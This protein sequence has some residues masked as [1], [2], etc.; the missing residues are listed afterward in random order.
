MDDQRDNVAYEGPV[1][2]SD[3]NPDQA[4]HRPRTAVSGNEP[5]SCSPDSA[6]TP[7]EHK[8]AATTPGT[9]A[10]SRKEPV[11][12]P[13]V[14]SGSS[15]S[16]GTG[17]PEREQPPLRW[18]EVLAVGLL[19]VVC[20]LT[21]Y[22]GQGFAGHA[23]LFMA[24]PA[25]LALGSFRACFGVRVWLVGL[26]VVLLAA[27]MVWCGSVLLVALGFG[28]LVAFA[29]TLSGLPP[30][31]LEVAVFASQTI[32][33][34]YEGL[35]CYWRSISR[36][37]PSTTRVAWLNIVLPLVTFLLFGLLFILANPDLLTWFGESVGRF[38]DSLR[39]WIISYSPRLSEVLFCLAVLWV[40]I[41][42]LRPVMRRTLFGETVPDEQAATGDAPVP[43]QAFLYPAFRNTLVTVIV[44]FASYLVF[45]FKTLWFRVFPEG[46]YYSGYAHEGAAWLTLALA[47]A[48]VILSL[49]F[50]GRVLQDP[51]LPGLRRLAW[52]WSVENMVLAGAVYNRLYIYIGFNGMSRMRMVGIFGMSAV[53]VGFILVLW[54]IAYRRDFFWLMRRHLW[55]LTL[56][57]YLFAL[58]PVD[59]IVVSYNARRILSGD[60]AP[61]VQISVHPINSE[62]VL[63]L[64]AVLE[65]QDD[66]IREGVRALLAKRHDEAATLAKRRR[67]QGWTAFQ[68]ADDF[69]LRGLNAAS[70]DWSQY[71]D[72]RQREAVLER[73]HKY[74]YQWY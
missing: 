20:D 29:M 25:L 12:P 64:Q 7:G 36:S 51:R 44:L 74:A 62:G 27:K 70:A 23:L 14:R 56:A 2:P 69:A 40:V 39:N 11:L 16:L 5:C 54:K 18:R 42:L 32:L 35:A 72:P 50:R 9:C 66:T 55:T 34:G 63:L 43:S 68:I 48:T 3:G 60:P 26:L 46:F 8:T 28:L 33:A 49:V 1:D 71:E 37:S 6:Q 21:I 4:P 22:R 31:V 13:M 52:V 19:V 57:V 24:A 65:C 53:V 47:L 17:R 45:E 67:E 15:S 10:E 61:C 38:L 73:F 30:Y 58:T 59:T 41:G